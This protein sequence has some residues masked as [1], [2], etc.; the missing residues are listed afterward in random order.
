MQCE[1]L[2]QQALRVQVQRVELVAHQEAARVVV[3]G[4]RGAGEFI[5]LDAVLGLAGAQQREADMEVGLPTQREHRLIR[6]RVQRGPAE[7]AGAADV[8]VELPVGLLEQ[9]GGIGHRRAIRTGHVNGGR[10][11]GSQW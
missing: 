2:L 3:G 5:V 6:R 11:R 8:D 10:K 9:A 4:E 1:R 7:L